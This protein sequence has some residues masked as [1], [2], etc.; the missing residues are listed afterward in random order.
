M[1]EL[2]KPVAFADHPILMGGFELRNQS[3]PRVFNYRVTIRGKSLL[4][5]DFFNPSSAP[6]DRSPFPSRTPAVS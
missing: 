1:G 3:V 6:V 5:S 2:L 4:T